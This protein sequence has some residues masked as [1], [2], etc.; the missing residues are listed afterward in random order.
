MQK[1][2]DV[3]PKVVPVGGFR[4][5]Q[6]N[7]VKFRLEY[8]VKTEIAWNPSLERYVWGAEVEDSVRRKEISEKDRITLLKLGLDDRKETA[9]IRARLTPAMCCTAASLE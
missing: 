3:K 7:K 5:S 6:L 8:Q 1:S 4:L 2:H 9:A